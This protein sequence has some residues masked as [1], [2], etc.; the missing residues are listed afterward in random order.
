MLTITCPWSEEDEP[1]SFAA[2]QGPEASFT[3]PDCGTIVTFDR[4]DA[5]EV[6]LAA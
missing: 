6:D 2:L 5:D 3:C 1:S 4:D